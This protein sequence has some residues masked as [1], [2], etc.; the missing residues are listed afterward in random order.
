IVRA[1]DEATAQA[2]LQKVNIDMK[3]DGGRVKIDD[4][5]PLLALGTQRDR[6][7]LETRFVVRLPPAAKTKVK[8][9]NAPVKTEGLTGEI[10]VEA[11]NGP[12]EV[13]GAEGRL[14]VRSVN[15]KVQLQLARLPAGTKVDADTVNGPV[16]V[17]L[18]NT[19][20][21]LSAKT[22]NGDI[23]STLAFPVREAAFPPFG[24]PARRYEGRV[25]T[26]DP[27]AEI[28]LRTVNGKLTVLGHGHRE[29]EAK[30]L[31]VLAR[32]NGRS[33]ARG[34]DWE[35]GRSGS[36]AR[37][38]RLGV[39]TGDLTLETADDV[40][41]AVVEGAAKI[42]AAGEVRIESVGKQAEIF[43]SG[44]DIRLG[45]V[46]GGLR[47]RT[48]GGDVRV[49]D[50]GGD[51]HIET[52][53]GDVRVTTASGA[54]TAITQGGDI[55][56][57]RAR[58]PVRAITA[59]G[60]I[61]VEVVGQNAGASELATTGGDIT[62]ILP[63]NARADLAIEAR[64]GDPTQ[65]SITSEFSEI[66]VVRRGADQTASGKLGGGGGKIVVRSGSGAVTLK[67]GPPAP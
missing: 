52:Q 61:L 46:K 59:G 28:E 53:G 66:A 3:F 1:A 21:N 57:R 34:I 15:G 39:V 11:V 60:D 23:V 18:P 32:G 17:W 37:A 22:L 20:A 64:G 50:A 33:L 63:S 6:A 41:A 49:N 8:T 43:T 29:S 14:R 7:V 12:V 35:H 4:G 5:E 62:L 44:G 47:A 31:V 56:L 10:H 24:P 51:A 19:S 30:P 58:G 27:A 13:W 45:L 67:K 36:D 65:P 26:G 38:G 54:I 2:L 42:K 9:V 16:T 48:G 25:G 55:N 40:R